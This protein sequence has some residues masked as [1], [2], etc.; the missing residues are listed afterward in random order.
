MIAVNLVNAL[1]VDVGEQEEIFPIFGTQR[2]GSDARSFAGGRFVD[3]ENSATKKMVGFRIDGKLEIAVERAARDS[4]IE[5]RNEI[6]GDSDFDNAAEGLSRDELESGRIN[7]TEEAVAADNEAE[8]F[9]ILV[10]AAA[11]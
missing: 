5:F 9:V 4:G 7:D 6:V 2:G 8:E 3:G 1:F 10:T 11:N